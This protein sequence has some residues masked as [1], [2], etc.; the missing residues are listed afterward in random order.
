MLVTEIQKNQYKLDLSD[1]EMLHFRT[2]LVS[3]E[4]MML[5]TVSELINYVLTWCEQHWYDAVK[6][7]KPDGHQSP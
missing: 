7:P 4:N 3:S 5:S 6:E 2:L 1:E